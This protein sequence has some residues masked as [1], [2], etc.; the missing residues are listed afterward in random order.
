MNYKETTE[1]LFNSL[2]EFQSIG[3]EAYK[4][5]LERTE[6]FNA[7]LGHPDKKFKS[8]H[9]A[10]TNGK[11]STSHIIASALQYSGHKT[12]LY[13][14]PHLTDFRERIKIDGV[15]ISE[16][17]VVDF[18][19]QHKQKMLELRLSFFEMTVAMAFDH[20]ARNG[21]EIAVVEVGLGGRL[22]STNI[23]V[24]EL[25]VVTNIGLDHMA[26]LG[27]TIEK[28]AAEKAGII[29]RGVPV[30]IGEHGDGDNV[31]ID[32]AAVVGAP[33]TFAQ[34]I[35]R[36]TEQGT[37]LD[38]QHFVVEPFGSVQLDLLG[39]YQ[40]RNIV[41][42]IAALTALG[43]PHDDIVEGCRGAARSTGLMGRW[44]IVG[45]TPLIVCDTGHNS[46]G[47]AYVARQI[48][49]TAHKRL[50]M[51]VGF[52]NDKELGSVFELLPQNAHY[53]FTQ[54]AISR[55]LNADELQKNAKMFNLFGESVSSVKDAIVRAQNIAEQGDMIFIGG[56]TF[57]VSEALSFIQN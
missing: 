23:I 36:V 21:V 3:S 56:S 44:Q 52:V 31:F 18:V 15:Q 42:A 10:G 39:D 53:I 26:L 43:V 22:D 46:H 45:R 34:D 6:A 33:I 17:E 4:P 11:G 48:E 5:G 54:A 28:I 25:C 38:L 55:A 35:F 57:V 47:I 7:Y 37:E 8:I 9:I 20:F 30:I 13:T 27:D 29:K 24:P 49:A 1:F 2:P 40:K 16:K 32:K 19:E 12:G 50:I 51:V 14:S 41:T